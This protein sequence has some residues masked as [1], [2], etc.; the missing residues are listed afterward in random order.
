MKNKI[1]NIIK[2]VL[3]ATTFPLW[4]IKMFVGI[5]H[6]PNQEGEIIEVIFRHSMYENICDGIHPIIAYTAMAAI[7]VSIVL[8]I[9]NLKSSNTRLQ[10]ISNV[11]FGA[12]TVIF[13][14]LLLYA[15]SVGRGY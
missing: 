13:I 4:F 9:L 2:I 5:G 3:S 11:V 14:I 12:A 8:N 1:F 6:L 15:S 10:T 7:S